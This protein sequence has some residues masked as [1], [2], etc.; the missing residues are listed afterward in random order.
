MQENLGSFKIGI[1]QMITGENKEANLARA[2]DHI[3]AAAAKGADIIV[4]PEMFNCPYDKEFFRQFSEV[5]DSSEAASRPSYEMLKQAAKDTGKWII[6]GSVPEKDSADKVYNT[7]VV[8]NRQGEEVCRHRKV[9]LFDIDV[10]G[11]YYKESE[12]LSPGNKATV[13]QTEY[14]KIGLAICYDIRFPELSLL[15]RD[16]G[17]EVLIFPASFNTTTGPIHFELLGK[18]RALDTQSYVVLAAPARDLAKKTGYQTWGHS[19]VINPNGLTIAQ[20]ELIEKILVVD[21]DLQD[22]KNQ[23]TSF[24]FNKQRRNDLY[25]VVSKNA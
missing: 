20:A 2:K 13:F 8:F 14:C 3:K 7:S 25:E 4:L 24:P 5:F 12:T 6:G 18:A 21:I 1:V 23:R 17:A 22:V 15:M 16:Q 11:Q 19:A 10:P 9:H